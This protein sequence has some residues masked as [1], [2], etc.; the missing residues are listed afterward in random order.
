MK[1]LY[2]IVLDDNAFNN[3][4][5]EMAILKTRAEALKEK[6]EKMYQDLSTALDTPCGKEVELTA[7]KVLIAPINSLL[8][9]I[10]HISDTLTEI[11]G[12]GYYKDVFV[13]FEQLNQNISF[14]QE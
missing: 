3:A 12:T 8:A 4:S 11:I 7:E 6:L 2:D 9:V 14:N 5:R 1:L 10:D 13:K